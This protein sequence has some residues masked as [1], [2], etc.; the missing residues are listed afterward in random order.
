M[1]EFMRGNE[2]WG[3]KEDGTWV[4][5]NNRTMEWDPQTEIPSSSEMREVSHGSP[6]T[7][8]RKA[9]ADPDVQSPGSP[10]TPQEAT[11]DPD[12]GLPLPPGSKAYRWEFHKTFGTPPEQMPPGAK[13]FQWKFRKTLGPFPVEGGG[14]DPRASPEDL[15]RA[16]LWRA[17]RSL[18]GV[19]LWVGLILAV[20]LVL[21]LLWVISLAFHTG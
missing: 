9:D 16:A 11:I 20:G 15:R 2:W 12:T 14:A 5:W 13:T 1:R 3:L 18:S 21:L 8:T 19:G 7:D 6:S 10:P 17:S 4:R